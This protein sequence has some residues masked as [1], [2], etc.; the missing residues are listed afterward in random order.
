M[1]QDVKIALVVI[2]IIILTSFMDDSFW[3][4]PAMASTP[5]SKQSSSQQ[6]SNAS[7]CYHNGIELKGKVQFVDSFADL[8]V[9]FVN[10]F[11]DINVE[12][13][14]S[15]PDKCGQWQTVNSFP[16]FT[17]Q[18]VDSFPDIEVKKVSSFPG[19]N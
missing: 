6:T 7:N 3:R 18:E 16:D 10:S 5:T 1:N 19:M 4:A 11:A 2:T 12:F 15:F 9:K 8:K 14:S 17:I 13:V